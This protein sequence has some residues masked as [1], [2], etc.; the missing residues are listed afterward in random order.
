MRAAKYPGFTRAA[1][2]GAEP[3]STGRSAARE[4]LVSTLPL[5]K[6]PPVSLG[7]ICEWLNV[8]VYAMPCDAFGAIFSQR[9][10]R[11]LLSA[12]SKL[13]QGRFRFSIAHELG[14]FLLKHEPEQIGEKRKP[15]L[16][17]QA[18]VFAAELL[19]PEGL[20]RADRPA[21]TVEELLKRY[22]VSKQAL[23]IQLKEL[24]LR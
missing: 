11:Y 4:L 7:I 16:E 9:G 21:H 13:P 5:M 23:S 14:H 17:R 20:L 10:G 2:R 8:N 6:A 15:S 3:I 24:G 22:K 18:D 1:E 12:N 19:L